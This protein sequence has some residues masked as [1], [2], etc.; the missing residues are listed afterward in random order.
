MAALFLFVD[1]EKILPTQ[2]QYLY[3]CAVIKCAVKYFEEVFN[4]CSAKALV[5]LLYIEGFVIYSFFNKVTCALER[6]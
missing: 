6:T 2:E 3:V 4:K 5:F 1:C